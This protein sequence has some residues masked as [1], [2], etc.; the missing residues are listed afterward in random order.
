M[1]EEEQMLKKLVDFSN[2]IG[3]KLEEIKED[4]K[5]TKSR[6]EEMLNEYNLEYE[7]IKE[8]GMTYY[9]ND[10]YSIGFNLMNV[11]DESYRISNFGA[12]FI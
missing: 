11:D 12:S 1:M 10:T 7:E 5:I 4:N 8:D 3:D 2:E 6:F 9:R